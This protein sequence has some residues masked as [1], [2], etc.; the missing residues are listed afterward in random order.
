MRK[1][2]QRSMVRERCERVYCRVAHRGKKNC[3]HVVA[4][5]LISLCRCRILV[6]EVHIEVRA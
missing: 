5:A 2:V 3:T 4:L 1:E 6:Y